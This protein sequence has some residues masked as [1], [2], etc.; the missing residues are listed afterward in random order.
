MAEPARQSRPEIE[1]NIRPNL[2]VIKGGGESTDERG[3]LAEVPG[4]ETAEDLSDQEQRFG[5]IQGGGESTDERANLKSVPTDNIDKTRDQEQNG[6]WANNVNGSVGAKKQPFSWKGE[7]RKRGP[8]GFIGLLLLGGGGAG[9]VGISS[10]LPISITEEYTNDTNDPN[11]SQQVKTIN[12]FGTKLGGLQKKLSVCNSVVSIRCKFNTLDQDTVKKF[13]D[14]GFQFDGKENVGE[15]VGVTTI[16]FPGQDGTPGGGPKA[17]SIQELNSILKSDV[18]AASHFNAAYSL[19]NSIFLGKFFDGILSD[20]HLSKAKKISGNTSDEADKSF[21]D[22]MKQGASED[23]TTSSVADN[24]DDKAKAAANATGNDTASAVNAALKAGKTVSHLSLKGSNGVLGPQLI[25]LGYNMSTIISTSAKIVKAARY[26]SFA[27]AILTL[28]ASIKANAATGAEVQKGVD[29]LAPSSYPDQVQDPDTGQMIDNPNKG[30]NALDSEAYKVV[31]YGDSIN[32]SSIA[33]RL[34]IGGAFFG[35]LGTALSWINTHIG[36]SNMKTICKITNNTLTSIVSFLAAPVF[37]IALTGLF[38][39]LPV[40]QWAGDLVNAAIQAASGADITSSVKGVDAGNVL[41]IGTASLMGAT[42]MHF[43]LKPGKLAAIRKNMADNQTAE[44]QQVA[45]EQYDARNTPFAFTN[46][47]SFLG[48]IAYQFATTP[49]STNV[50]FLS[51]ISKAFAAFPVSLGSVVKSASAAYS[52]PVA[53]YPDTRFNQCN[54]DPDYND[55]G[56]QPDMGCVVR[57]VPGGPSA[58]PNVVLDYMNT[59]QQIDDSGNAKPGSDFEKYLKYCVNRTDPWGS[60][61]TNVEDM[62]DDPD[63]YTGKKCLDDT[64][65]NQ[66]FSDYRGYNITNGTIDESPSTNASSTKQAF[67]DDPSSQSTAI[68]NSGF[69]LSNLGSFLQ[70]LVTGTGGTSI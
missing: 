56:I 4:N 23:L 66:M 68:A 49:S 47:Y 48:S 25:C 64:P 8:L 29:I 67:F 34:F 2:H 70:S 32:L 36:R 33:K 21:N 18:D 15:R 28:A 43:G 22:A 42:S 51:L 16:K 44:Q 69:N 55:V 45:I 17:S 58:D 10:L 1:P 11:S 20:L 41:F 46:R 38:A 62:T 63:W 9:L 59:Y 54:N 40:D 27:M 7:L 19:K 31:A 13:E 5:V 37:S 60:T 30:K 6:K 57:Y 39:I 35:V 50:P 24:S 14:K 52:M 61:S 65:E 12:L 53:N 3:N 26:I